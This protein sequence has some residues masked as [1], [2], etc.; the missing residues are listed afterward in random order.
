MK[1][2]ENADYSVVLIPLRED[3]AKNFDVDKAWKRY[4]EL[5][6]TPYGI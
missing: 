4:Y 3:L 1:W 5:E 2:A 6:D